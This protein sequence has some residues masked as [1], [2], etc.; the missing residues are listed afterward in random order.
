[1]KIFMPPIFARRSLYPDVRVRRCIF[2]I[3]IAFGLLGSGALAA[4]PAIPLPVTDVFVNVVG[5][6]PVFRIPA[7]IKTRMGTLLAFAE[8]R[9]TRS[10]GSENKIVLKRSHDDGATWGELQLVWED[11]ANS[12]NNPTVVVENNSG[13]VLLMFQHYPKDF[14]EHKVIPGL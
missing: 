12:L 7:I 2:W 11:G 14:Y 6:Y 1:M 4:D 8:A 5:G 9:A 13:V 10:D 3:L